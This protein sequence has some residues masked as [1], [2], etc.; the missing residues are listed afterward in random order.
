M[1]VGALLGNLD[2]ALQFIEGDGPAVVPT[3]F[4]G[5]E[6]LDSSEG[7]LPGSMGVVAPLGECSDRGTV[8]VAG[9]ERKTS[10]LQLADRTLNLLGGQIGQ[11]GRRDDLDKLP[12]ESRSILRLRDSIAL[13]SEV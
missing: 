13:Q 12:D 3:V 8:M 7:M 1:N 2:E 5:V 11:P 4:L 9:L 10:V 6:P